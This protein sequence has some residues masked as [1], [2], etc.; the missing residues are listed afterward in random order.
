MFANLDYPIA[1]DGFRARGRARRRA[2]CSPGSPAARASPCCAATARSSSRSRCSG[3]T[4]RSA[5][6]SS[7]ASCCPA[8]VAAAGVDA[9]YVPSAPCGGDAAVPH[10]PRRRQL[11]RRRRLPAAA[12]ATRAAPRSASPSE[13]LAFANVPGEATLERCSA[14]PATRRA[15]PALEGRRAARRRQR[16]GL[17]RRPRPLPRASCYGVDPAELRSVDHERYLE[18]SRAVTGEVMAEVFGEWRRAGS[19]CGGG[20]RALAARPRPG[21]R[22]GPARPPRRAEGRLPPPAP[23]A[24]AGRRLDDRRGPRRHRRPRRQRPP[25]A[26]ARPAAG[27]PLP[28]RRAARRRGRRGPSSCPP[29]GAC[30]RDVEA[31]LGRF[32]DVAWAYRFGPPA[33]DLVV[34]SLERERTAACCPR[35]CASR[36]GARPGPS[37]PHASA[38][39][40][41]PSRGGRR[42]EP[43][44]VRSRR[45]AYG[46]RV[47]APGFT[48]DD[49]AFS[50]SRVAR[51]SSSC[52]RASPGAAFAGGRA[53]GAQPARGGSAP[54]ADGRCG[55]DDRRPAN[56]TALPPTAPDST[57]GVLPPGRRGRP[58]APRC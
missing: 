7:S 29:H 55:A 1:D 37:R 13:C 6:A 25:R 50:S 20:H 36:P 46:V 53:H 40:R 24:R 19:P 56:A 58:T 3:S 38:S 49:D 45:L 34:A 15:R 23:R 39:R 44:R 14:S 4:R 57:F 10:R 18:L 2:P 21:R 9:P 52:V 47:H 54:C 26:A 31:L 12:R 22:L 8:L 51:E 48:A 33:Q 35:R 32:V 16:L 5:A 27:R 28:R 42:R 11:L 30:E 17:R 43:A 41:P